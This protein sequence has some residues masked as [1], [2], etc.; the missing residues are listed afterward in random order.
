MATRDEAVGFLYDDGAFV[1]PKYPRIADPTEPH[2]ILYRHSRNNVTV[3]T[4]YTS[5]FARSLSLLP[6]EECG[7]RAPVS[8]RQTGVKEARVADTTS[9]K[10]GAGWLSK[11]SPTYFYCL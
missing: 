10:R 11:A 4:P 6:F 7:R 1:C 2:M 3:P 8:L 5:G 9:E